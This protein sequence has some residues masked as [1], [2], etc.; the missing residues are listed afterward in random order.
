MQHRQ[1]GAGWGQAWPWR[2]QKPMGTLTPALTPLAGFRVKPLPLS[3]WVSNSR[4]VGSSPG[5]AQG[6]TPKRCPFRL[7]KSIWTT[8]VSGQTCSHPSGPAPQHP[9]LPAGQAYRSQAFRGSE[10]SSEHG[11]QSHLDPHAPKSARL[12][13]RAQRKPHSQGLRQ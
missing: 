12:V 1:G 10:L 6:L 4:K 2:T 11:A 5:T 7:M 9:Q 8:R 3:P 13:C